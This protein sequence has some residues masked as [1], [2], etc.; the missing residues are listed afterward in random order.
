MQEGWLPLTQK[1]YLLHLVLILFLLVITYYDFAFMALVLGT[2]R[3]VG[4]CCLRTVFNG[5]N[6]CYGPLFPLQTFWRKHLKKHPAR[7]TDP[8]SSWRAPS[9]WQRASHVHCTE[10]RCRLWQNCA[11]TSWGVSFWHCLLIMSFCCPNW[12]SHCLLVR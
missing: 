8:R 5:Y 6:D 7:T 9:L 2:Q 11:W 12:L 3:F 1:Y 10:P 4:D